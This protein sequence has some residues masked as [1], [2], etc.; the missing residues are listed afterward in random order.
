MAAE[1][2]VTICGIVFS[3]H[4]RAK[5][6]TCAAAKL[7]LDAAVAAFDDQ[8]TGATPRFPLMGELK[9]I[10]LDSYYGRPYVETY[11]LNCADDIDG[12]LIALVRA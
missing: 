12:G 1:P 2:V 10:L 5:K 3:P 4:P 8:C 9:Q 7:V 6:S 11:D